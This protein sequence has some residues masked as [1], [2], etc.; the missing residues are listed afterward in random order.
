M[1]VELRDEAR[2]DFAVGAWFYD[3]QSAGLGDYF[4][5]CLE[6]DLKDLESTSGIHEIA[7]GFQRKLSKKFPFAIYYLVADKTVDVV[8]I[9][10]CRENPDSTTER[11][12]RTIT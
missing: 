12:G 10:D 7:H 4:I 5:D 3:R 8:A 9:L 1:H 2:E 11:L 6:S